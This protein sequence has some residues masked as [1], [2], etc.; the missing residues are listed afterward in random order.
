MIH[1]L[2]LWKYRKLVLILALI[3]LNGLS[4]WKGVSDGKEA[5]RL[6]NT[7]TVLTIREELNEIRNNRPDSSG[8]IGRLRDGTF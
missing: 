2:K 4:Y 3:G 8:V 5:V 1:V 7:E 6:K